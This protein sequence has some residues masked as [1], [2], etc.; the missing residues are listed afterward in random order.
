MK[1]K[2]NEKNGIFT[3][4]D[5]ETGKDWSNHFFND[6]SYV[7]SVSHTG[8]PYS[9]FIDQN[10]VQVTLNSPGSSF[11][12]LRD[13]ETKKYWNIAGYP[14]LNKVSKYKCEHGQLFTRISS[15]AQGIF[16]SI[17]Y[18]ISPDDT[19]EVWKVTLVNKTPRRRK[20]D[21]FA[22]TAFDLNGY[23]Q[24]VYY[25][26]VTTSATE[27]VEEINGIYNG[28][29]NPY[30]PHELSSGYIFSSEPLKAYDGNYESFIGTMGTQTKPIILER[31]ED[32][33]N[34]EATVRQ[35]GG[36]LENE[37]ELLPGETKTVYY[38]LGLT[39]SKKKLISMHGSYLKECEEIIR[40]AETGEARFGCLHTKCPE[41]QFNR[42]LN[43][44]AEHQVSYCALGKKAVRD[45]AQLAMAML[46]FNLPL[47]KKTID[48]CLAHEY[49]DG[50]SVL[51]WYPYLEPNI[52][53]DPSAWLVFAV[54]G[55]I[56]ESGDF[57]YLGRQ[58]PYL[59]GKSD[60]VYGHLK[61]AASW[62]GRRDNY[63][64]HGLP[65]IHHADW[66]DAL[67]I[68]D[69]K[70]ESVF[71][72]MLICKVYDDLAELS[73]YIGDKEYAAEL[74]KL[75]KR[76]A[77]KVN[78]AAYNGEYYVRAFS[79]FGTVGDKT[80]E[81][82]G[83][84]YVNPQSWSI[85][86]DVC[87]QER[88]ESVLRAIDGMETEE[89]IPLCAPSYGSYDESV[90]RMSGMLP[91]VYENGGI[92]NHAGCF[93][94]MADCRL[95]RGEQ[96][97]NTLKKIAPDG[98]FNPSSKTTTEPYVFTNCYLKHPSVDM[99]VGFSWQTGSSAWGLMCYYEGILG[100]QRG[101]D[102]LHI[103]PA[104]PRSWRSLSA[105]RTYRGNKLFI[106]YV[107]RGGDRISLIIDGKKK[108]GNVV[109]LFEDNRAHFV[110]VILE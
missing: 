29:L 63:G 43:Y 66:N 87:P 18:A 34:S 57:E 70:A 90:G 55:Y 48:E 8:V 100:L 4:F 67:N 93:K 86:S 65:R 107:N 106:K 75:K 80:N 25:S 36:I 98:E 91:G 23:A 49:S 14:S 81:N 44:W 61:S 53:S 21:I 41:P 32:C 9:R 5:P 105:E 45:N 52:Y 79:K 62:F 95:G 19:R 59:D 50:H 96:A 46:N 104:L 83:K 72:A 108:R 77:D 89:G 97:V 51:T 76:L 28:N 12:Y 3:L 73:A 20:I 27:Y 47:A 13:A 11:V 40:R 42:I 101:Y 71:M 68:P 82:G 1:Y 85:L 37:V 92:Y 74:K 33:T 6:L 16:A 103:A 88:T 94:V 69:E 64:E 99:Q 58:M 7:M 110:T 15:Q 22:V 38:V 54:C 17:V 56:K 2:F 10:A 78:D 60:T 30:R 109:P 39:R 31:G 102:G 35:R 24:P 26:T 84:I